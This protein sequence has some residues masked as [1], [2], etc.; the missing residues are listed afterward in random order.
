[1]GADLPVADTSEVSDIQA[2]RSDMVVVRLA[3]TWAEAEATWV[4]EAAATW[5]E[6]ADI[7]SLKNSRAGLGYTGSMDGTDVVRP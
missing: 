4:A 5:E 6:A 3:A 1:L 2:D 7:D